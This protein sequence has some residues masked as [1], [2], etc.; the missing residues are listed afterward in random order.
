[1]HVVVRIA[2][3]ASVVFLFLVVAGL[4]LLS[5]VL[6]AYASDLPQITAL[7]DYRPNTIGRVLAAD[8]QVIGE[9]AVERRVVVGFDDVAPRF[10]EA[11][12]AA[13]DAGFDTHL[14]L[15]F[16]AIVFRVTRDVLNAL[17]DVATGRSSRPAGASTLTQQ[18]ARNL[19]A[20][21]IGFRVGDMSLERKIKEA[22]VAMQ[23]EKRYTKREILT[24]YSNQVLFG[25]GTYGIEA[26]SRLYFQKAAKALDLEEAALLAGIVQSPARQSPFVNVEAATRR[27]NYVLQ[28]MADERYLTQE[29]ADI[30]KS[31]PVAVRGR[32]QQAGSVAPYFVEEVRKY[33]EQQYGAKALY[34]SGLSVT[35]TLDVTLQRAANKALED[36]LRRLDKRRGFRR[37]SRNVIATGEALDSFSAPRW[38]RPMAVA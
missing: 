33:V 27:R 6:F 7:D 2:R 21:E 38:A 4:G 1:M 13:E 20:E 34:E 22:I 30:A 32:P 15:S 14:G 36:G 11:I 5:G 3:G 17:R 8:G 26:A 9:F 25:H 37:P 16:S 29:E 24:L 18:L 12:V 28:R 31:R 10:R 23:I 35:T 19:F